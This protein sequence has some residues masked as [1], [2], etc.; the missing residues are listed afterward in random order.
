M[1][2]CNY[3][4][5]Y[6]KNQYDVCPGCG[7][8]HFESKSFLGEKVI[9]TPPKGGYT[10]QVKDYQKGLTGMKIVKWVGIAIIAFTILGTLPFFLIG[11]LMII[12]DP[13][14]AGMGLA[15]ILFPVL[16][17]VMTIAIGALMIYIPKKAE[18][19]NKE[20]IARVQKLAQTGTLIKNIPYELTKSN[21]TDTNGPIYQIKI[22]YKNANGEDIPLIS[23]PKYGGVLG[24]KSGTAD[25]LIDENDYSNY[26]IDFEI[27]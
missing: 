11:L 13:E 6:F 4:G 20:E 3:C 18:K 19:K 14:E 22:T 23:N 26:Y 12:N 24:S 15:F 5:R 2:K 21:I 27:Y 10:I 17:N 9:K 16:V 1:Y 7:S 25:L 8:T